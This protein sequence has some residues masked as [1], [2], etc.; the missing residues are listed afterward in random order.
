MRGDLLNTNMGDENKDSVSFEK[1]VDTDVNNMNPTCSSASTNKLKLQKR[2]DSLRL[3]LLQ[4]VRNSYLYNNPRDLNISFK[5][6]TY[7][8][9]HGVFLNSKYFNFVN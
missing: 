9:K 6:I 5:D 3:E 2:P 4:S 8:V 7:T 1:S